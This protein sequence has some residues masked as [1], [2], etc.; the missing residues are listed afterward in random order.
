MKFQKI[1]NL[2]TFVLPKQDI[3]ANAQKIEG[4]S[5]GELSDRAL[6][7]CVYTT[8]F[9]ILML[10]IKRLVWGKTG[11]GASGAID[12]LAFT[13]VPLAACFLFLPVHEFLH[14]I[15]FPGNST[16]YFGFLKESGGLFVV[17]DA[18]M[19]KRRYIVMTLLPTIVLTLFLIAF[20]FID[21]GNPFLNDSVFFSIAFSL[22]PCCGDL[23]NA[24]MISKKVPR[25]YFI[26]N[27]EIDTWFFPGV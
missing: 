27:S 3:P 4:S 19:T 23:Y 9:S 24:V 18:K 20:V 22:L 25:N 1:D 8:L 11:L 16:V 7:F 14:A 26:Q 13:V 12:I 6:L 2:R 15:S 21:F 17:S 5:E 10:F